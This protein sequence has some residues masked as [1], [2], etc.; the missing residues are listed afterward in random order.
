MPIAE[1]V[2][3]SQHIESIETNGRQLADAAAKAGW[4]APIPGLDWDVRAL[5]TH[6]GGVHRW[7]ADTVAKASREAVTTAAPKNDLDTAAQVGFGPGDDEL[8]DWFAQGLHTLV[9]ALRTAPADIEC[10]TFLPAPSPLAFWARRQAHETAVHRADAE[11]ATGTIPDFSAA[12]AQDGIDEMLCGFARRRNPRSTTPATLA[13][14]PDDAGAQWLVTLGD[15]RIVA[16]RPDDAASRATEQAQVSVCGS[17]SALY[18]WLWN[19][20]SAVAFRGDRAAADLWS[21]AQ[22]VRWS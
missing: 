9:Q 13:L 16:T 10:F 4:G 21:A 20:A 22:R 11:A 8:L 2:L 1:P 19:R 12:F 3:I 7:A 5:V 14:E 15:E 18:L 6:V 17:S